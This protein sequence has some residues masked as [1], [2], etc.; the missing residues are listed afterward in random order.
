MN[1]VIDGDIGRLSSALNGTMGVLKKSQ[2]MVIF[3]FK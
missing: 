2:R 1:D 3:S